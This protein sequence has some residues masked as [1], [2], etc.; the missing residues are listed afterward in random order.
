MALS[1]RTLGT[2]AAAALA[3]AAVMVFAQAAGAVWP[4]RNGKIVATTEVPVGAES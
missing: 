3:C 1:R 2:T 4:G